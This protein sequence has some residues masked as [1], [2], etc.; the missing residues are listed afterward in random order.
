MPKNASSRVILTSS[1]SRRSVRLLRQGMAGQVADELRRRILTGELTEGV[2]LLQEQLAS[3]FGISKVPVREALHQLAAEGFV[4]QEFHRGATVAGL[5]AG[6]VMEVFELRTL[7]E[8][9]LLELG[10]A[11]ATEHDVHVARDLARE[12][13]QIKDPADFPDL[14]W[15][16]HEALYKPA[17]KPFVLE[18]LSHLHSHSQRYVRMQLSPDLNKQEFVGGHAEILEL[19]SRKDPAVLDRMRRHILGFAEQLTAYLTKVNEER[20]TTA[21]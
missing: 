3:E 14:N 8:V 19:Y 5:S 16:F 18:H 11:A 10:M 13:D 4:E 12:I 21:T 6:D 17:G 7:I 20:T 2:Q 9:W 15:R 1:P